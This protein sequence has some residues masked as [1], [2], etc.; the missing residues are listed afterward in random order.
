MEERGIR[1]W[2]YGVG[3]RGNGGERLKKWGVRDG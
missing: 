1:R 2:K 3:V